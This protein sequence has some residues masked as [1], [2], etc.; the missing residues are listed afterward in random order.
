MI[1]AQDKTGY[2]G[3]SGMDSRPEKARRRRFV[4]KSPVLG[5]S[6]LVLVCFLAGVLITYYF[7]QVLGLGYQI[8]KLETQLALLRVENNSLDE[9]VHRLNSLERV[10]YLAV[11][12]LGMVKPADNNILVVAV[13]GR[14][15]STMTADAASAKTQVADISP[16]G[17]EKSRLIRA[18]TELVDR[19]ENSIRLGRVPVNE[20]GEGKNADNNHFDPEKNNLGFSDYG[21]G[22][23]R[24]DFS[25]GLVAAC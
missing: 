15:Q 4:Q 1:V 11:N 17:Q 3:F 9:E 19:L 25:P 18:F 22:S 14:S 7:S 23:G 10:E 13:A 8:T 12:K 24:T 2:R 21:A 6:G 16:A 5:L 20:F